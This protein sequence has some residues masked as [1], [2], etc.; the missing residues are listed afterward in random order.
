MR[1]NFC[2][3]FAMDFYATAELTNISAYNTIMIIN[4]MWKDGDDNK[5]CGS[6]I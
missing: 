1:F 5:N 3:A 2:V 6:K 4:I